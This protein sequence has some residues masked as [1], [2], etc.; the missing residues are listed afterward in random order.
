MNCNVHFINKLNYKK[1]VNYVNY[2][3]FEF[4]FHE[5]KILNFNIIP[6]NVKT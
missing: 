6:K 4:K 2:M 5:M 1:L 3:K